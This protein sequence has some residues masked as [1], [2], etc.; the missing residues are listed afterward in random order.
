MK[1]ATRRASVVITRS[2]EGNEELGRRLRRAGMNPIPVDTI[3]LAPP[4]KWNRV[5]SSLRRLGAFEWV[6]FTS[7]SGVEFFARRM[8]ALSLRLPKDGRPRIAAV[9][10]ETAAA[11][12]AL[13]MKADFVPSRFTTEALGEELPGKPGAKALLLRSADANPVLSER[14]AERGFRVQE[15][16]IYRTR[17]VNGPRPRIWKADMIVFAS[18]S[19]V[20]SF[21]AMLDGEEATRLKSLKTVC[22]GP[23]TETAARDEGFEDTS[24]PGS[25]TIDGVVEEVRRL[26]RGHA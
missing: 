3:S 20:R 16:A 17:P 4:A 11:L 2:Q 8:K 14:L 24:T 23:V 12:K 10:K 26:S 5:D 1:V 15:T 25:F 13:G 22:I 6:V 7:A 21:C 18:P 19:A 9:G